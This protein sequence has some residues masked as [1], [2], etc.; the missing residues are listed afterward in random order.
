MLCLYL[1]APFGVFRTM[2]TGSFRPTAEFITPSAA[3]GLL[4]NIAGIEMRSEESTLPMTLIKSGL[5]KIRVA[6]AALEFPCLHSV[7]QQLHNYPVGSTGKED[8]DRTKGCKYNIAPV[9][10]S[11]LSDIHA[12]IC[13]DGDQEVE[14]MVEQGMTGKSSRSYGLPFLGDNSFSIDKLSLVKDIKDAYW[15]TQIT[16]DDDCG[17][18][19]H[20]TRL[21]IAIDRED[22]SKTRSGLF[23]PQDQASSSI[24]KDAWVEVGY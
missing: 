22:M 6:L 2:T 9:R 17:L 19:E 15:Y 20:V 11:F 5:P 13:M 21:T 8:A 7:Y 23:A 14:S 10:R 3:Y 4:L 1:Q 24:P 18:K 16:S 12:Y